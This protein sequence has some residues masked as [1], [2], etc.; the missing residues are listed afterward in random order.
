[1]T[2]PLPQTPGD[3]R[4]ERPAYVVILSTG[5]LETGLWCDSCQLP[6]RVRIPT[7]MTTELGSSDGPLIDECAECGK[8]F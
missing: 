2:T 5:E 8:R 3:G 4:C 6:S 1:M 7:F